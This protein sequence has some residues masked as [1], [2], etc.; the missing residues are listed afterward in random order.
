ML[1][2]LQRSVQEDCGDIMTFIKKVP[3][4]MGEIYGLT[5]KRMAGIGSKEYSPP[6]WK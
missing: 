1:H 6:Q 4:T 3:L 5:L 2:E